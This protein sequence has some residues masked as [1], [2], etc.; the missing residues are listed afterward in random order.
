M[1][2]ND[3]NIENITV[4]K[5]ADNNEKDNREKISFEDA[6]SKLETYV[7]Q[8]EQGELSLEES[9]K[10]FE[11]GM[12]MAKFCSRELDAAERKIQIIMD[13]NGEIIKTDYKINDE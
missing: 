13:K 11:S 1:I 2:R 9:L 12:E 4:N 10:I 8:L 7:R 6:L 5:N 3:N